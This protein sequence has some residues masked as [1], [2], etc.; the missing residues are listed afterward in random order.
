MSTGMYVCLHNLKTTWSN[1]TNFF[2]MLPIALARSTSGR[3]AIC[4]VLP[5]LRMTSC[6]QT[7]GPVDQN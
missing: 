6:F 4:Y 1:L 2:C 3:V 7:M 5:V